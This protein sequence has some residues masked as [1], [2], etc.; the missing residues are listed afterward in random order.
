L[1]RESR[2][3][4]Y[5]MLLYTLFT[6]FAS[7]KEAKPNE[8]KQDNQG[9]DKRNNHFGRIYFDVI[10][11]ENFKELSPLAAKIYMSML[12]YANWENGLCWPSQS[13]IAENCGCSR[14]MVIRKIKELEEKRYIRKQNKSGRKLT[15]QIIAYEE[16]T[17]TEKP[18]NHMS[19]VEEPVNYMSQV[20][21]TR[22]SHELQPINENQGNKQ[23]QYKERNLSYENLIYTTSSNGEPVTVESVCCRISSLFSK[24]FH[25]ELPYRF[26]KEKINPGEVFD[27]QFYIKIIQTQQKMPDNP[28]GWWRSIDSTW[29]IDENA[30]PVDSVGRGWQIRTTTVDV[31]LSEKEPEEVEEEKKE[32][33]RRKHEIEQLKAREKEIWDKV[34]TRF[35]SMSSSEM[36]DYT[37]RAHQ[38]LNSEGVLS[39]HIKPLMVATINQILLSEL[40]LSE[41]L[42][43]IKRKIDELES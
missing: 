19:Q 29:V 21:V 13:L 31:D 20:G 16:H 26:I 8:S 36:A 15:Y 2:E 39:F 34:S 17:F 42:N 32:R 11:N 3:R 38:K 5:Q 7:E 41:E 18:V 33:E 6:A 10:N 27:D 30:R 28:I 4:S 35:S 43:R 1:D 14:R 37:E 23:Q 25:T 40:G 22:V 9:S 12:E 24:K